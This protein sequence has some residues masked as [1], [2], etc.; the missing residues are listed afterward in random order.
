MATSGDVLATLTGQVRGIKFYKLRD[1]CLEVGTPVV[2]QLDP[3]NEYD[4]NCVEIYCRPM[5]LGHLQRELTPVLAPL[6]RLQVNVS[7]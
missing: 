3:T 5:K 7:G 2:F 6:I 4:L 1:V